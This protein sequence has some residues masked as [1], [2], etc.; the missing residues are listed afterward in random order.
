MNIVFKFT[1]KLEGFTKKEYSFV[2]LILTYSDFTFDS[3]NFDLR[4]RSSFKQISQLFNI[5][6]LFLNKLIL[7]VHVF[8][9]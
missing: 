6:V 4:K 2:I 3:I 8:I 9:K 1:R 7:V 5:Y